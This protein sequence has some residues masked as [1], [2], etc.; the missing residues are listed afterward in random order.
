MAYKIQRVDC[1]L[2]TLIITESAA[3]GDITF[4]GKD[5]IPERLKL[6]AVVMRSM[7]LGF[8]VVLHD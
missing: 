3:R 7:D 5:C 4:F 8:K 1:L 2:Q 6:N